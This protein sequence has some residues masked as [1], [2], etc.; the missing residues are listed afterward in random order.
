METSQRLVDVL[1]GALSKALPERVPAASQGTMNNLLVGGEHPEHHASYVYYETIAGGL[2]ARPT[3][4]GLDAVQTH[5]TN[6]LNTPVEALEFQFPF[7]VTRY[8]IRKGSGGGG[9]YKGGDGVIREM[10]FLASATVTIIS[11]R[12]RFEPFG[13]QGGSPGAP[14]ENLLLRRGV[15]AFRLN[16]KHTFEVE[17]GD[18]LR[19][20]TPGGGGWAH[21]H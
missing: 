15:E 14:G 4:D 16:A 2:G 21:E 11:E 17:A 3:K 9:L 18:V 20:S 5:M 12:R 10:E 13:L 19:I 8:S 6:T 1:F 7:R